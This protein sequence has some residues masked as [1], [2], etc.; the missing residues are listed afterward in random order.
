MFADR[1]ERV[2]LTKGR[3]V[4]SQVDVQQQARR[5]VAKMLIA[6]VV[7]FALC[8]FPVHALGIL[9]FEDTVTL[10]SLY[11]FRRKHH[12][13]HVFQL[14]IRQREAAAVVDASGARLALA[15]LLQ[16]RGQPGHLQLHER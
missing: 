11:N 3:S 12:V 5:N 13:I 1:N 8:Y 6:V 2:T 4:Q 16:Q 15:L 10:T 14:Q 7:V 9:R